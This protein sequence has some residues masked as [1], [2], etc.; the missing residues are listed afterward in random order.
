MEGEESQ[1]MNAKIQIVT[2]IGHVIRS[3]ETM[4]LTPIRIA[5]NTIDT[6]ATRNRG[7][8]AISVNFQNS[9]GMGD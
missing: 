2:N 7:K 6:Y 1:K 3:Q 9:V 4:K 5:N 8:T